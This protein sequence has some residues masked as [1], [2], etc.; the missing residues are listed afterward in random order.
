MFWS[1]C[2]I[3]GIGI[4]NPPKRL[5]VVLTMPSVP[6]ADCVLN[7]RYTAIIDIAPVINA[8]IINATI[9][10]PNA[11]KLT[12]NDKPML[13]GNKNAINMIGKKR[14]RVADNL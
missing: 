13:D 9:N 4:K 14:R 8:P 10:S 6:F 3:N 11:V 2:G 1:A 12:G 7:V 5:V